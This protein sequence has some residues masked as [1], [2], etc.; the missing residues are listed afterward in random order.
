M[1]PAIEV[2]G[3]GKCYRIMPGAG[4][5]G[6]R[7]LR[8]SL[9]RVSRNLARPWASRGNSSRRYEEFWALK[10][11]GFEV[12]SGA[13]LGIIGRNGA[14]KSTL[15]KVLSRITKPTTGEARIRGRVGSLLEVGTGFHPE[16]SGRENIYLNGAIL[17]MTRR[18]IQRRFDEIVTFAGIEQFL[19]TPIKRYSS[20]MY[21]RLA[22]AVAA[23]LEPEIL[24]V[25]EVLAVGDQGFQRKC[26]GRMGEIA[27]SGRTVLL[28]SHDLSMLA[29]LSNSAVW[30]DRGRVR[31]IGSSA[32]VISRYCEEATRSGNPGAEASLLQHPGRR[33]GM[34]P[35][36][37]S[38]CLH[39]PSGNPTTIVPL[40]GS[41]VVDIEI[42]GLVGRSDHTIMLDVCDVFGTLL[43][44]AHS[45]VHSSV[46][47]TGVQHAIARCV[48]DDI[49][50]L[51]NDY[52]LNVA[53]GDSTN[54]LDRVESAIRFTVVP[55]DIYGTGKIPR[56]AGRK[57]GLFA[58]AAHWEIGAPFCQEDCI[59]TAGVVFTTNNG[60]ANKK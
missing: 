17:G 46:D 50:L 26:I 27:A 15:L 44:R 6:Y 53:I 36:L 16:L 43:G 45:H 57:D 21:V 23:H 41:L 9:S 13:V 38:I 31:E 32:E 22:F 54:N 4:R 29:R 5:A 24:V 19:E 3:L 14:G 2:E 49:R 12:P 25:D 42:G 56:S 58:L 30:L 35:L 37:Q 47:L 11:V 51:P 8:E 60:S 20:G 28:V 40:G 10:D 7:T 34:V 39:D 59:P 55:A 52:T 48:I 33:P 1:T 18:E